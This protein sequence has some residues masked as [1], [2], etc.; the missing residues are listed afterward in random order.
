MRE[1]KIH[2]AFI[3]AVNFTWV[4]MA[5]AEENSSTNNSFK[6]II[7]GAGMAGL[8]AANHLAKHNCLDFKILEART[9]IGGRI[10]AIN[11]GKYPGVKNRKK[12][13]GRAFFFLYCIRLYYCYLYWFFKQIQF[14]MFV[15]CFFVIIIKFLLNILI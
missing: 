12:K 1:K 13:V 11:T 5:A 7:I 6:V 14:F 15:L 3:S 2:C 10:V 4:T 8:S 9:R